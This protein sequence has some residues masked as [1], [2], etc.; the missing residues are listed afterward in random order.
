M[1]LTA[2]QHTELAKFPTVLRNLIDAELAAGNT[3]TE[4]GHGHPAPPA[5]ACARLANKVSTRPRSTGDGLVFYERN[6]S[7]YSGEFT[8]ATRFY[9]VL[10]APNPPPPE[11]DMD[12]IRK[13]HEPKPDALLELAQRRAGSLTASVIDQ[14]FT[15]STDLSAAAIPRRV[16]TEPSHFTHV[17]TPTGWARFLYFRDQRPPHRVA[18]E[19]ERRMMVLFSTTMDG[20]QLHMSAS[21]HVSGARYDFDLRFL[22]A[23]KSENRFSL[24]TEVSWAGSDP[25]HNDY[26]RQSSDS[27]FQLWTRGLIGCNPPLAEE[28][29]AEF[30]WQQCETTLQ[31]Q[32]QLNCIAAIQRAI[33]EGM[34]RGDSF[35][36][37]HKEGG[38]KIYWRNGKFIRTDYGDDP[39][40]QEF[41]D[42]A[43]FLKMLLQFWQFDV[44]RHAG[45]EPL[46]A[47]DVWKLILRKMSPVAPPKSID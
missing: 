2:E 21:A 7:L 44:T 10:E 14:M 24:R 34:R 18:L 9:F 3:L 41:A 13:A 40:L 45:K 1:N 23:L 11:P 17:Q 33:L 28:N 25:T 42:E 31:V 27:W 29:V 19:L 15:D 30:Y 46:N 12:A 37:S 20:S 35:G 16:L 32:R 26:F 5:G 22:A 47:L 8:D 6:S 4:L 38:T 43:E 39:D 36:T